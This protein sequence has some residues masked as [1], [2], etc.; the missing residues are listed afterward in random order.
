MPSRCD[1]VLFGEWY[2]WSTPPIEVECPKQLSCPAHPQVRP[3]TISTGC[4]VSDHRRGGL[5]R[6]KPRFL[7]RIHCRCVWFINRGFCPVL[8]CR[9]L[10]GNLTWGGRSCQLFFL[11]WEAHSSGCMCSYIL[12]IQSQTEVG[13]DWQ[14]ASLF[15]LSLSGWL[16]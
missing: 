10:M 5:H 14:G 6:R 4:L 1:A 3:S 13:A 7:C 16:L 12:L 2:V 15:I 11:S 8:F 9:E